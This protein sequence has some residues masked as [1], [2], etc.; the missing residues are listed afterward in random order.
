MAEK[1]TLIYKLFVE[2]I[3]NNNLHIFEPVDL[4][5]GGC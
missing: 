5:Q 2:H 1:S 3:R 4:A